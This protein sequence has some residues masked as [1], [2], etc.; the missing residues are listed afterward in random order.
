M[1]Q[2]ETLEATTPEVGSEAYYE[3]L[4]EEVMERMIGSQ[5][6]ATDEAMAQMR[7]EEFLHQMHM[8][9]GK[10]SKSEG[11]LGIRSM[12]P[13]M[14]MM[15]MMSAGNFWGKE[16]GFMLPLMLSYGMYGDWFSFINIITLVLVWITL[17]L[18]ILA[19]IKYLIKK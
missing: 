11:N 1:A 19:L 12:R 9:L 5:H 14:N 10:M 6:E 15:A 18:V 13:M 4:G 17:I 16:V 7:G 8:A 3:Q 2:A